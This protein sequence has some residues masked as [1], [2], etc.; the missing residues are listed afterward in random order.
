MGSWVRTSI[1]YGCRWRM[2]NPHPLPVA[3]CILSPSLALVCCAERPSTRTRTP[4]RTR[5]RTPTATPQL[6]T[7]VTF[8]EVR[9]VRSGRCH[10][11][12]VAAAFR[13]EHAR[14]RSKEA[15]PDAVLRDLIRNWHPDA[16]RTPNGYYRNMSLAARV[17]AFT[18]SVEGGSG[19]AAPVVAA[20]AA[21][22]GEVPAAPATEALEESA[23]VVVSAG[24]SRG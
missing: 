2:P 4:T 8:A 16:D 6:P 5:T 18:G 22:A 10:E 9:L 15:L 23:A 19:A 24:A 7:A 20:A 1:R 11:S 14:Y 17:N 21:A 3:V 13:R 12:E